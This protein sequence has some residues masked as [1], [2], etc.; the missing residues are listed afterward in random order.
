MK[1]IQRGLKLMNK[2]PFERSLLKIQ[3]SD[4]YCTPKEKHL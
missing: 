2:T 3:Y 4:D 1:K